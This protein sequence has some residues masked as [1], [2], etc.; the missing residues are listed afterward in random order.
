MKNLF[1]PDQNTKIPTAYTTK[2][3]VMYALVAMFSVAVFLPFYNTRLNFY[4]ASLTQDTII[5]EV[6]PAREIEN[7]LP[8]NSSLLLTQAAQMKAQDMIDRDY[9]AHNDPEGKRPWQWLDKVGYKYALAGENLA[10]DFFEVSPLVTAWLNSP[11]HAKNILNSYFTEIGIGVATGDINGQETTVV[12]M[13]VAYPLTPTIQTIAVQEGEKILEEPQ[14]QSNF[15]NENS[16]GQVVP[17]PQP[18]PQPQPELTAPP[19]EVEPILQPEEPQIQSEPTEV[20]APEKLVIV[21][22]VSDALLQKEAGL[23]RLTQP[24]ESRQISQEQTVSIPYTKAFLLSKLPNILK[25]S[26]SAF[27]AVLLVWLLSAVYILKKQLPNF[28]LRFLA[29]AVLIIIVWV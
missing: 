25:I 15:S 23:I 2:A 20:S 9:F 26:L 22:R 4:L 8:L 10:K 18:I 21:Q 17:Q 13:F 1:L 11:S 7:L 19:A 28:I 5:A 6:N 27:F 14:P 29:L 3:L 12:A 24:A 16:N